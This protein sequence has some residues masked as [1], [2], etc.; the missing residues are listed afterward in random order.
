[1]NEMQP[2]MPGPMPTV[3][4]A[5]Q[6]KLPA[7]F[8]I[9]VG[10]IGILLGLYGIVQVATGANAEQMQKL[11]ADQNV[12]DW[13]KQ[14]MGTSSATNI[15]TNIVVLLTSG[16]VIFGATKMLKLQSFGL[17]MASAI[18]AMVPCLGPCCCVGLPVGIWA[19]VVLNKPEVKAAFQ[20]PAG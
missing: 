13:L 3:N 5:E 4:A 14:S 1:M 11:L 20:R 7:I 19:L 18:V 2:G 16:L 12:P 10:A 8:L 15:I 17:A 9:I 6:V